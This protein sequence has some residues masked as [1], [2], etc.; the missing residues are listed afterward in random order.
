MR[1]IGPKPALG[2]FK[3]ALVIFLID[4]NLVSNQDM[5]HG[6]QFVPNHAIYLTSI[7]QNGISNLFDRLKSGLKLRHA[8]WNV[9]RARDTISILHVYKWE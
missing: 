6:M 9:P 8:T 4:S 7:S 5:Q 2:T 1:V 3:M